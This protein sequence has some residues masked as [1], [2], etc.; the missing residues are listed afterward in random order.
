MT[1]VYYRDAGGA[2]S[3]RLFIGGVISR[4]TL[5]FKRYGAGHLVQYTSG[6][7]LCRLGCRHHMKDRPYE[8]QAPM[9]FGPFLSNF[10]RTPNRQGDKNGINHWLAWF[11]S[12]SQCVWA[13]G[14]GKPYCNK[15]RGGLKY[16][17]SLCRGW[18]LDKLGQRTYSLPW[19][20]QNKLAQNGVEV[21]SVTL[22]LSIQNVHKCMQHPVPF[23]MEYVTGFRIYVLSLIKRLNN[24]FH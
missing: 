2:I 20:K 13:N 5:A 24:K 19:R 7:C 9:T 8:N 23:Y 16:R 17:L 15:N 3:W 12:K 21:V 6:H 18:S 10:W 22:A 1:L 14:L 11:T 4:R